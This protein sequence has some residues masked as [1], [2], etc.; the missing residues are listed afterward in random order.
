[1]I[2]DITRTVTPEIAVWPGD[3]PYA[4]RYVARIPAGDAVNVS[5]ITLSA[6]TGTHVDAHFHYAEE[7]ERLHEMPLDPYLGPATVLDLSDA[8]PQGGPI[9]PQHLATVD[10]EQVSRLLI[11]S[12]ASLRPDHEWDEAFVYLSVA[13]AQLLVAKGLRLFGTDAPSVDPQDSK[14]MDAHRALFTGRVAILETLQ[15]RD[16]PPGV[17]ELIALPLKLDN[18]GSPVRAILRR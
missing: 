16:V 12:R 9:Q 2:Y 18:D 5:A 3:T 13:A 17:Y 10:F 7:G 15:L 8:L 11:K 4:T 14:S 6:H 1:M